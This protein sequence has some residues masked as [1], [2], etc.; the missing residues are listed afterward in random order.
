MPEVRKLKKYDYSKSHE[1]IKEEQQHIDLE[2]I[3]E[4]LSAKR[5]GRRIWGKV[6]EKSD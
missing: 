2:I 5:R 4:D 6:G 3:D 1:S